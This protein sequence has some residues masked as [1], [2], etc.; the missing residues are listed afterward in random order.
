MYLL[1]FM[2]SPPKKLLDQVWAATRLKH[3]ADRTEEP[4]V[5]WIRRY[6]LSPDCLLP[7]DDASLD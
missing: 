3:Y 4:Y 7:R 1:A 2:Q 6:I 5:Q